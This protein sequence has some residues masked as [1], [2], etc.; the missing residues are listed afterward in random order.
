[1][2][3]QLKWTDETKTVILQTFEGKWT[4][5]DFYKVNQQAF[6]MIHTVSH[7]V[8]IFSDFRTSGPLPV[9]GAITHARNALK[10]MP[11]NWG[12]LVIINDGVLINVMVS[13]FTTMFRNSMGKKTLLARTLE[14]A[15]QLVQSSSDKDNTR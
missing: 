8:D 13:A 7:K 10:E 3:I 11:D 1:M 9:G 15:H 2:G 4:W 5:E 14:E 12:M 6:A